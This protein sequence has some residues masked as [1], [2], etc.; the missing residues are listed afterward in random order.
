MIAFHVL[1]ISSLILMDFATV[2][3]VM[4]MMGLEVVYV[5]LQ[6]F[7]TMVFALTQELSA[8]KIKPRNI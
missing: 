8:T 5:F 4:Q 6:V 2:K 3:T 1:Q 7:S